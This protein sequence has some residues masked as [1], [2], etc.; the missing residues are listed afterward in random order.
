MRCDMW[1]RPREPSWA[2]AFLL[3][4][5]RSASQHDL[6]ALALT[7][8]LIIVAFAALLLCAHSW[9]RACDA[10]IRGCGALRCAA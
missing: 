5:P 2:T 8:T 3:P 7:L 1:P 4:P 6:G 9:Q 10:C